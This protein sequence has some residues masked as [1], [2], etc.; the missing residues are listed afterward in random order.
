MGVRCL[1][2]YRRGERAVSEGAG[3]RLLAE[4]GLCTWSCLCTLPADVPHPPG[5]TYGSSHP[6]L[7]DGEPAGQ[8]SGSGLGSSSTF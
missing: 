2:F 8:G 4:P 3:C 5:P 7:G 1:L 6:A